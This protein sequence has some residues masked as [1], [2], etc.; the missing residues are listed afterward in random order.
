MAVRGPGAALPADRLAAIRVP[1]L[2]ID[3]G[4]G[5]DWIRAATRAVADAIPG[6]R[7]VTVERQDHGVLHQ[8][9]ALLPLLAGFYA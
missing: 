8:P 9:E 6:A 5:W 1:T 2:A 7:Y 4:E 3:G